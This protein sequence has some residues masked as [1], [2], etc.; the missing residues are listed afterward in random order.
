MMWAFQA[1]TL[2]VASI[3]AAASGEAIE[4]PIYCRL[5]QVGLGAASFQ[6]ILE[7]LSISGAAKVPELGSID[8]SVSRLEV[9]AVDVVN[10][11]ASVDAQGHFSIGVSRLDLD[12]KQ[13]EW[14]YKQQSWPHEADQGM[15]SAN[16]SISFQVSIDMAKGVHE[17]FDLNLGKIQLSMGAVHH[18]WLARELEK[19]TK[20]MR[21]FVSE[22]V[23]KAAGKA[24]DSSLAVIHEQG[25]CAF[26]QGA[27]KDLGLATLQFTSYEPIEAHAPVIGKMNV[28]VNSTDITPPTTMQCKHVAFNGTILTA[29][30]ADV[31]FSAG[32]TWAY[33]QL[34]SPFR[35]NRGTGQTK[36][37]AGTLLH[38]DLLHPSETHIQVSLP[39]LEIHLQADAHAWMYKVLVRVMTPLIQKSMQRLG[40]RVLSHFAAK[41][42]A[43][44]TC[45]HLRPHTSTLPPS[46]SLLVI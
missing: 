45:P 26:L 8:L 1:A 40:G 39:T 28:S 30:I 16:T 24:L 13:L 3:A 20:F 12:L 11:G 14:Q 7:D 18:A 29:Q 36:I 2:A 32:F 38:V 21:P 10:C 44:P 33:Q 9:G 17:L 4:V 34:R 22:V 5:L 27:V 31:P 15:A 41:C 43:D 6:P 42:L 25:A 19:F 35:R 23:K 46:D 37:T